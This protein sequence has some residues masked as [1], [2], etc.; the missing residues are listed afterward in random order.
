MSPRGASFAAILLVACGGA[1][2]TTG[3]TD[4]GLD[5]S[6]DRS[7]ASGWTD[8]TSP[9]GYVLCYGP[10]SCGAQ[11]AKCDEFGTPP[12]YPDHVK[13]C[14]NDKYYA[15]DG[16]NSP[17]SSY[18]VGCLDGYISVGYD[19]FAKDYTDGHICAGFNLGI[20]YK[21]AGDG[22]AVRYADGSVFTGEP[23]PT[24]GDCPQIGGLTLCG[25]ACGNT[26]AQGEICTGRS[27]P[28]PYSLCVPDARAWGP[29]DVTGA[30][31]GGDKKCLVMKVQSE[32]QSNA[33]HLGLCVSSAVCL[34]AEKGYPG[35]AFCR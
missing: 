28:H 18:G 16:A 29:C 6:N 24:P 25:G 22:A 33:N 17:R 20:L 7:D 2:A 11:C 31:G 30:C 4:A 5:G 26:C 32:A 15:D 27:P 34:A 3:A 19:G 1:V 21:N 8:C 23:L 13:P 14:A 35:G 9:D 12:S 10:K